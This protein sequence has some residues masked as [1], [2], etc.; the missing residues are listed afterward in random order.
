MKQIYGL[1]KVNQGKLTLNNSQI[2]KE[3]LKNLNGDV[4]ITVAEGRGKRS[5]QQNRYYWGQ[6]CTLISETTGYTPEEVH[7]FLKEKFLTDKKH[8]VIAGEERDI[9]QATT[10]RLTTKEFEEYC[11]N[12]RRWASSVLNINIPDPNS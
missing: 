2:F 10:T 4:V 3:E 8:I 5:T 9:E 6:V 7:D 12:I 1:G 11:E